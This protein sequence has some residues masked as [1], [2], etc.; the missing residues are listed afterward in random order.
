MKRLFLI[1][2]WLSFPLFGAGS[3]PAYPPQGGNSIN[4]KPLTGTIEVELKKQEEVNEKG[5][6]RLNKATEKLLKVAGGGKIPML[7]MKDPEDPTKKVIFE[8]DKETGHLIEVV[9]RPSQRRFPRP[10]LILK[11]FPYRRLTP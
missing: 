8:Y 3:G 1:L 4:L 9:Y 11:R 5:K 2:I 6:E 7:E 10:I